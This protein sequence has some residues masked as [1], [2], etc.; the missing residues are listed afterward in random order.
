MSAFAGPLDKVIIT[1]GSTSRLGARWTSSAPRRP[2]LRRHTRQGSPTSG[3]A[4]HETRP[5]RSSPTLRAHRPAL[6]TPIHQAART[7]R[8]RPYTRAQSTHPVVSPKTRAA[9]VAVT[10]ARST[11]RRRCTGRTPGGLGHGQP[12]ASQG[13]RPPQKHPALAYLDLARARLVLAVGRSRPSAA[14]VTRTNRS[15]P[16]SRLSIRTY[17]G[18]TCTPSQMSSQKTLVSTI[19]SIAPAW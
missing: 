11:N 17:V 3:T 2:R 19:A 10:A 5:S 7:R 6:I 14:S 4:A 1:P 15:C 13:V 18:W 8:G 12:A 16:T 9:L